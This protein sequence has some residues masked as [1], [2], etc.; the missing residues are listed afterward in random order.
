[1][2]D[3]VIVTVG[4]VPAVAVADPSAGGGGEPPVVADRDD[5][6]A[7]AYHLAGGVDA[8][9]FDLAGGDAAR[10]D[11]VADGGHGGVVGGDDAL[12]SGLRRRGLSLSAVP[13]GVVWSR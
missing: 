10:A 3:P 2:S 4:D 11:G 1:M 9:G 7:D 12:G 13:V 8:A 5:L 6:V